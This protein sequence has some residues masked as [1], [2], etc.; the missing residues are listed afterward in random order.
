E[1][2]QKFLDAMR[3]GK[4]AVRHNALIADGRFHRCDATNKEGNRGRDDG[5]YILHLT[6]DAAYGGFRNF[7]LRTGFVSWSFRSP[8]SR[9]TP[10]QQRQL[11]REYKEHRRKVLAERARAQKKAIR[12]AHDRWQAAEPAGGQHDFRTHQYLRSKQIKAHGTRV[13]DG[14]LLIPIYS[15]DDQLVNLH[16]INSEGKKWLIEGGQK[17]DTYARIKAHTDDDGSMLCIAE[18]FS[19]GA[20]IN[21]A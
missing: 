17:A 9:L 18:G 12:E 6:S 2:K 15:F 5:S 14:L 11:E 21:E 13:L 8:G 3:D 19:T 7:T 10:E 4:L 16:F 1:A 20:S